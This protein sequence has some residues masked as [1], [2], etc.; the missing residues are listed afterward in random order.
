MGILDWVGR[1]RSIK[2]YKTILGPYLRSTYGE[3]RTYTPEQVEESIIK[4][5][6]PAEYIGYAIA[7]YS[8]KTDYEDY[9]SHRTDNA[10][11]YAS[12][13]AVALTIAIAHEASTTGAGGADTD[14]GGSTGVEGGGSD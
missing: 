12:A 10:I 6:L 4:N 2:K 3:R 1:R 9:F 13:R 14:G 8:T 11:E 5:N 7:M